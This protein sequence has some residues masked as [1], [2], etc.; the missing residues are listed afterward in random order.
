VKKKKIKRLSDN[1]FGDS[2]V[3]SS[4]EE[5]KAKVAV[6]EKA[7]VVLTDF[8]KYMQER[9]VALKKLNPQAVLKLSRTI[10]RRELKLKPMW[11]G[12]STWL[13]TKT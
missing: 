12:N 2:S 6:V 3:E 7:E 5:I 4:D 1:M 8:P 9:N 11:K 13:S 10:P